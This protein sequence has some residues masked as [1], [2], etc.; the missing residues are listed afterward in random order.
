MLRVAM[1]RRDP[2]AGRSQGWG[3]S[4]ALAGREEGQEPMVV[5]TRA[6]SP[7]R[8]SGSPAFLP[9]R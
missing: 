2:R 9:A 8:P 7:P 4:S 6:P 3:L 1:L 5:V